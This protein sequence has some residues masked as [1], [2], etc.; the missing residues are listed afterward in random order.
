MHLVFIGGYLVSFAI[1]QIQL[2]W[3][4]AGIFRPE[5]LP[6]LFPD[7]RVLGARMGATF[8]GLVVLV[9]IGASVFSETA[10][11]RF[12]RLYAIAWQA[13]VEA[14]RRMWAPWVVLTVF[15]VVLAF[16]HWFL[17]GSGERDAE[18]SRMFVGTLTLLTSLLLIL[19][20]G[21][22]SPI[23]MPHDIQMQTIYTV[24]SKPV[25]R[26]EMIWGRLIGYMGLVTVLLLIF[27]GVSLLYLERTIGT[28]IKLVRD[29]AREYETTRPDIA[30][31]MLAQA[32]QLQTRM[33]A[34]VPVRGSLS[35]VDSNRKEHT[36]GIDVGQEQDVRSHIE[37]ATPSKAVW[38]FG[39]VID[40][41]DKKPI[42]RSVP[43]DSLIVP[44]T[45]E[46]VEN[47]L[48]VLKDQQAEAA[49]RDTTKAKAA[50]ATAL[51][52]QQKTRDAEIA[53]LE[54]ELKTMRETERDLRI[55]S[56]TVAKAEGDAMREKANAMH[57]PPIPVE[58]SFNI[59]RTTK[60]VIGEPVLASMVVTNPRPGIR[61]HRA[62][63]P[64]RE[65]Y[66]N[67][68]SIPASVLVGSRGNL[69]VEVRC[70]TPNQYLGMA[71]GDFYI[72]A[73]QGGFELNFM[74]GLFGIWL[75]AMV[76]TSIGLFAGTF[77][78]WPVALLTTI[79]FFV[80]GELAFHFLA[81]FSL[82]LEGGGPFESLIR[83]LSHQN[84]VNT[85]S[86]TPAVIVAK[87]F[88]TIIMPVMG[89]LVYLVPNF[90]A[91]DV[92]N[93][94]AEGFAVSW[95]EILRLCLIGLG[96]AIPFSIAAYFILK[97]REVAA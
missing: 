72:L 52:S 29:Q 55:K 5:D 31:Q 25:R 17:R 96:Y 12:R 1:Y 88:D 30:K 21:I 48:W 35:F 15:V 84:M 80:F 36:R 51:T 11:L 50:D 74:K 23:G 10:R 44:G 39:R 46:A 71:E 87:T 22:V 64:I 54:A 95:T 65:Y 61:P 89:R 79:A 19:M 47:R 32:D 28:R 9:R 78:S 33:S 49:N 75:Q 41:Y 45:L 16:T 62:L 66:T 76:L 85:L 70:E 7:W 18:L 92:T 82:Q 42:D 67:K 77:L 97:N 83:L 60:G 38:R 13:V 34:R 59:Y 53:S 68:Q 20:V 40:P 37:G 57:S 24:V 2:G 93:V 27:G 4:R 58:M 43:V 91:L 63:F 69:M 56:R 94:V 73:S 81:L 86:P 3:V 6:R 14:N 90:G 8:M 26:L